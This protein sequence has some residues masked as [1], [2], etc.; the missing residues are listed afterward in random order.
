MRGE[1]AQAPELR[2]T[3][4]RFCTQLRCTSNHLDLSIGRTRR[5]L[6][7]RPR[8][9]RAG[10]RWQWWPVCQPIRLTRFIDILLTQETWLVG[11]RQKPCPHPVRDFNLVPC[12]CHPLPSEQEFGAHHQCADQ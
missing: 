4:S 12:G 1:A 6:I 3:V 5:R 2:T 10:T 11:G 9:A 7:E 8:H